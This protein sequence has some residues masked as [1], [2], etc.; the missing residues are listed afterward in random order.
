MF[1]LTVYFFLRKNSNSLEDEEF[2]AKH[3]GLYDGFTIHTAE[4]RL[5]SINMVGWFLFRR[6]LT[7]VN[8]VYLRNESI[9]IQL[10]MNMW[11]TLVDVCIKI[12]LSPYESRVGGLMEKLN[13]C[14]VLTYA[15]FPYLFTDLVPKSEDKYFIGWFAMGVVGILIA[16]NLFVM[17]KTA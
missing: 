11:L 4:K 8:L 2:K 17:L 3:G 6:F 5:A 16:V 13:D 14:I 9:W 1:P 15:Y 7:G 12:H 10:T